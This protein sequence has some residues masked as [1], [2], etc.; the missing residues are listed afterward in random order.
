VDEFDIYLLGF[1]VGDGRDPA[2]DLSRAFRLEPEQARELIASLPRIVKRRV[3][4]EARPRYERV[5]EELGASCEFRRS[6]IKPMRI[7]AVAGTAHAGPAPRRGD[8]LSLPPPPL[9]WPA[10]ELAPAAPVSASAA[11][12]ATQDTWVIAAAPRPDEGHTA[13]PQKAP[14]T[15]QTLQLG[16]H[17]AGALWKAPASRTV[18]AY[19]VDAY[20]LERALA[21]Q[22][23]AAA[24]TEQAMSVTPSWLIE[25][26]ALRGRVLD[27]EEQLA[28]QAPSA[29]LP[30]L[31]L[32]DLALGTT[33]HTTHATTHA[34][35][36]AATGLELQSVPAPTVGVPHFHDPEPRTPISERPAP[37]ATR[38]STRPGSPIAQSAALGARLRTI[39][40][41]YE[42]TSE[43]THYLVR[44]GIGALVFVVLVTAR[45][46]RKWNDDVDEAIADWG[47]TSLAAQDKLEAAFAGMPSGTTAEAARSWSDSNLHHFG[48]GDKE[49]TLALITKLEKAG[50]RGVYAAEITSEGIV[51]IAMA[52]RVDLPQDRAAR[53]A[54]GAE[55]RAYNASA[56]DLD[57][58]EEADYGD[59]FG[60]KPNVL[61]FLN[62]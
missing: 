22:A 13:A 59:P 16:E 33:T 5:L 36:S 6:P 7:V 43:S 25:D 17:D 53:L 45:S 60:G 40:A 46:Y 52:L 2:E 29:W 9:E 61:V 20:V 1:R 48:N 14:V 34:T 58:D 44:F 42:D 57:P 37:Y 26:A 38:S 47:E 28:Q 23:S 27:P 10:P 55:I 49:R 18:P 19:Q 3:S 11:R 41:A 12:A 4:A 56:W 51:R 21:G 32:D 15:A 50:A 62:H 39:N 31:D 54:I 30:R 8:T 35:T 24:Q